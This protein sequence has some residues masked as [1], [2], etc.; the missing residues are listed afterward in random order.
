MDGLRFSKDELEVLYSY[1]FVSQLASVIA[2]C[3]LVEYKNFK[4]NCYIFVLV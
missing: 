3:M 4:T 2:S 1:F